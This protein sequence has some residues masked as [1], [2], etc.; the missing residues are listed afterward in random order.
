VLPKTHVFLGKLGFLLCGELHGW[1]DKISFTKE[2]KRIKDDLE[3]KEKILTWDVDDLE[4]GCRLG[5]HF[6][7]RGCF[8]EWRERANQNEPRKTASLLYFTQMKIN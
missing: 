1:S 5:V 8:D 3:W 2:K 6:G 7:R 4:S